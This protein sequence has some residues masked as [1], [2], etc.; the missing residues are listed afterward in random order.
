MIIKRLFYDL[1]TTGTNYNKHS[2]HQLAAMLVVEDTE[3]MRGPEIVDSIVLQI[4]PHEKAEILKSAL[5]VAGV[6]EEQIKAYEPQDVQFKKFIAFLNKHVDRFNKQDKMYLC[7]FNISSFDNAF[8]DMFFNLN[9]NSFFG[10][11]FFAGS[12]D[13][14]VFASQALLNVRHTMVNFKLKTVA[15]TLNILVDESKLHDAE[16]DNKLTFEVYLKLTALL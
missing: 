8:L 10:A 4:R 1:E 7:G 11:Y 14:L 12:L 15:K 5:D 3:S 2:I 13:V 16:Y 9:N 6:T